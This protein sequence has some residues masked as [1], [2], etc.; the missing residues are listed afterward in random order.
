MAVTGNLSDCRKL[1]FGGANGRSHRVVY[2]QLPD[3]ETVEVLE[4]VVVESR[5]E[6]YV[7]LLASQRMGRLPT[8]SGARFTRLH[9]ATISRRG[10]ARKQGRQTDR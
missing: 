1:Y 4:V 10:A 6:M 3:H 7:Y 9:Q 8:E 5:S 2:R